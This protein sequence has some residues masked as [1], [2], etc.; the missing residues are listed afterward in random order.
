MITLAVALDATYTL[1]EANGSERTVAASD[2]VTANHENVLARGEILR[3]IHVPIDALRKHHAHRR[4]TLT[5]LGRSTAFLMGTRA[6][7]ERGLTLTITAGTTRPVQVRFDDAPDAGMVRDA[8]D[9]I[10][11][12]IWFDDAN[13]TPQHRRHLTEH[14]AEEIRA[15]LTE[16]GK[17]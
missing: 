9:A 13:G 10:P 14:F 7:D 6:V 17:R 3:S 2:F 1:W 4:F 11:S 16:G 5:H 12:D 8:I 15:E